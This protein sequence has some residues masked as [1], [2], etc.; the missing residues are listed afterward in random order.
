MWS[1][2]KR[3]YL[4]STIGGRGGVTWG[5]SAHFERKPV[6]KDSERIEWRFW[7]ILMYT[8]VR[9]FKPTSNIFQSPLF[10]LCCSALEDVGSNYGWINPDLL[11][12]LRNCH[13][14]SWFCGLYGRHHKRWRTEA[15]LPSIRIP[16]I[17]RNM[18]TLKLLRWLTGFSW[19]V[20]AANTANH[21]LQKSQLLGRAWTFKPADR[22]LI[23][24][25]TSD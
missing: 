18:V 13:L 24:M 16:W 17:T 20:R 15:L 9:F 12:R 3:W 23:Q 5:R 4:G 22:I 2:E 19:T 8:D 21:T 25:L 14:P 10:T 7:T 11:P 1:P 6:W